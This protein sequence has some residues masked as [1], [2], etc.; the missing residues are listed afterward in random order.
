MFAWKDAL[1][2]AAVKNNA[3][4]LRHRQL[5]ILDRFVVKKIQTES[6]DDDD[7]PATLIGLMNDC[8]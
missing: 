7:I 5:V 6:D 2:G 3:K 8:I 1:F 4:I